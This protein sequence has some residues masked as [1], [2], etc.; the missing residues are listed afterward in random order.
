MILLQYFF[1]KFQKPIKFVPYHIYWPKSDCNP[2]DENFKV[3]G[4]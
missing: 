1:E 4:R 2:L 3:L